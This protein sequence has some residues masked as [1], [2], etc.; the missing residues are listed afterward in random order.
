MI[1]D[2]MPGLAQSALP[3]YQSLITSSLLLGAMFGS[4]FGGNLANKF[5]RR[6]GALI[7]SGICIFGLLLQVF[8]PEIV[9]LII[10]RIVIGF[11]VGLIGVICPMYTSETAPS[12]KKG[13]FGVLFQLTLTF[14]IALANVA[15]WALLTYVDSTFYKW[16]IMSA[17][18]ILF[19]LGLFLVA[20]AKMAEISFKSH[21][22]DHEDEYTVLNSVPSDETATSAADKSGWAGFFDSSYYVFLA[23]V[24]S[25]TLQLTGINA[26]MF[27]GPTILQGTHLDEYALNIGI[28]VW[29]FVTTLIALVFVER[30][31]RKKLMIAGVVVLTLAV[32][33]V[34]LSFRV[35]S[36]TPQLVTI[37]LGLLLYLLGFEGGPGCLFW[38]VVNEAFPPRI[39][40]VAG[41]FCNIVQW[42]FNLLISTSFPFLATILTEVGL[43]DIVFYVYGGIGVFCIVC[44][45]IF[46]HPDENKVKS[47]SI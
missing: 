38:V 6:M 18:G 39:R 34:G 2:L 47:G 31:G 5:G 25:A 42:G 30:L 45:T 24:F 37:G 23:I 33:L 43:A 22:L 4:L 26:V 9:T 10:F 35:P 29:N 44:L 19:P 13:I 16:R 7:S 36:G 21:V 40:A 32:V 41:S 17:I 12:D 11:G 20:F 14:G 46:W 15:G 27:F 3:L 1:D 8:A 28:G